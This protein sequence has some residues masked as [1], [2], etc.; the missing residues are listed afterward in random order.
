MVANNLTEFINAQEDVTTFETI[1]DP[2]V[3]F[4]FLQLV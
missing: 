3:S 1:P 4:D 2:V